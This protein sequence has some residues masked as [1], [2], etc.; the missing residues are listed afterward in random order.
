MHTPLDARTHAVS[1]FLSLSL[2][3]P[4]LDPHVVVYTASTRI[5]NNI[6]IICRRCN[7]T[8]GPVEAGTSNVHQSRARFKT[9]SEI[10]NR[11]DG[12]GII[13]QRPSTERIS[14]YTDEM[15]NQT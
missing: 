15:I 6:M 11:Q 1:H 8:A 14:N 7:S 13:S 9:E 10:K 3:L 4:V 12:D 5:G 2:S